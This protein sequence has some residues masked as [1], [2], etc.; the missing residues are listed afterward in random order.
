MHDLLTWNRVL[1]E[2]PFLIFGILNL[3]PDSFSDGGQYVEEEKIQ[4][5]LLKLCKDG[6]NAIDVGA[7]S[8][9]SGAL[10]VTSQEEL[11][12]CRSVLLEVNSGRFVDRLFSIDTRH[13]NTARVAIENGFKIINDVSG[14]RFDPDMAKVMSETK[15]L[16]V[17]MHSRGTPETMQSL[18]YYDDVVEQVSVELE[19]RCTFLMNEGVDRERIMVDPG[20]GFAKTPEQGLELLGSVDR[21]KVKLGYPMMVGISRKTLTSYMLSGDAQKVPFDQRDHISA[22]VAKELKAKGIDAIRVHNVA[23]TLEILHSVD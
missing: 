13:A 10:E 6:A 12:R 8:T 3:T 19:Q 1:N 15:A 16:V 23:K 2:N 11:K 9:R 20:I 18:S 14:A 17:I 22:V 7:E 21:I 4:H 5:Q